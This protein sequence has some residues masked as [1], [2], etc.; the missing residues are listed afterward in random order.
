MFFGVSHIELPVRD[1]SASQDFY[2]E[3]LGLTCSAQGEDWVDLDGCTVILRLKQVKQSAAPVT[4]RVQSNSLEEARD[5]LIKLG[6][7]VLCDIERTPELTLFTIL[8]DADD[9][10][11]MIW[12]N[13]SEDEYGFDP[14]LPKEKDWH[15]D[16]EELL[17]AL[18]KS[19]PALFRSMAR[20]R[21][22]KTAE[23]MTAENVNT[24]SVDKDTVVR[25]SIL[26]TLSFMRH[27]LHEPLRELGYDPND[28]QEEFDA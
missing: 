9:H 16:A 23:T 21:I 28:Y 4:L 19:V 20:K 25:A 11:I 24:E 7:Q 8:R 6:A 22:T 13:L 18:L 12:R 3:G 10:R 14:Q 2:V 1:L 5:H 15:P 17:H 27:K 26:S